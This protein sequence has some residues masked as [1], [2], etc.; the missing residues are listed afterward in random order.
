MPKDL[1]SDQPAPGT[2]PPPTGDP[3]P[4]P[5]PA[6]PADTPKPAPTPGDTLAPDP[7]KAFLKTLPKDLQENPS[8]SRY[9]SPEAVARA[10]VN[11]EKTLGSEKVPIPKDPNDQEAWD[12]YYVAGGRPPEPK[13]Y[14]FQKPEK[15]PEGV[16]WDDN[17][18]GWWRQAA[19][20]S[21]LSQRQAQKLVDQ[22][23][24][25]YFAQAELGNQQISTDIVKGKA[26][27]QRDW[28]SEYEARRSLARAAFLEMPADIQQSVRDNG[29]ARMPSF[30]KYLYDTK[31][32]TTG[33]RQPRPP[34]E[35][36]DTS[37][38]AMRSKIATFRAQH[39]VALMD[40]SHPEH[41]LRRDEL[42]AMHNRLFP[43]ESAA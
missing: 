7:N 37:P 19:F 17:M 1:L 21:G 9:S 4:A 5:P 35:A 3:P 14:E 2:P 42:T 29:L 40:A 8:L 23:R 12:R 36:A 41:D 11:L 24:D 22:Y 39:H 20:E 16:I 33:E 26:E 28:G 38:E 30:I 32:R 34:G 18:E 13:A 43:V 10:Y 27:L 31:A 6:P 25:R 15:M